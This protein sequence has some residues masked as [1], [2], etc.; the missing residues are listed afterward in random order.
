MKKNFLLIAMAVACSMLLY[1]C[2][3]ETTTYDALDIEAETCVME[4]DVDTSDEQSIITLDAAEARTTLE[5]VTL[6]MPIGN[7]E[8]DLANLA[9]TEYFQKIHEMIE[10]FNYYIGKTVIIGG[11]FH[12]HGGFGGFDTIYHSV[13]RNDPSY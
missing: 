6:G 4:A 3:S 9:D 5:I 11:H 7:P 13:V 2:D 10:N 1:G 12:E 8:I